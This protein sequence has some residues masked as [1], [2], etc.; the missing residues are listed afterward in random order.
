MNLLNF[1]TFFEGELL[2]FLNLEQEDFA[3]GSTGSERICSYLN[4]AVRRAYQHC[5]W[6][7]VRLMESRTLTAGRLLEFSED[8]K[9]D[10]DAVES[11]HFTEDSALAG[12][13]QEE[14]YDAPGGWLVPRGTAS[15]TVYV[16]FRPNPPR[17]SRM[18]WNGETA[19]NQN[20][21]A[22][23]ASSGNCYRAVA[24]QSGNDPDADDGTNWEAAGVPLMFSSFIKQVVAAAQ[25]EFE[26][27]YEEAGR[28]ETLARDELFRLKKS[29]GM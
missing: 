10:I 2:P 20:D 3:A 28:R 22:Y 21:L 11:I 26:R 16:R 5:F 12:T 18:D 8:D 17:Y 29:K 9:T 13:A 7:E 6:N 19:Y 14:F 25:A 1:K 15:G 24:A 4:D 23:S 27:K